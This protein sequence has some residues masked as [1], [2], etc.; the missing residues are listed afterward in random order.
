MNNQQAI[1]LLHPDTTREALQEKSHE[2]S[3]K[4][5][6]NACVLACEAL[7]NYNPWI[8]AT[9][10]PESG[11]RVCVYYE[12]GGLYWTDFAIY[13]TKQDVYW[14]DVETDGF[15]RYDSEYGYFEVKNVLCWMKIP[16]PSQKVV[17]NMLNKGD[18]Q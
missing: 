16:M 5:I 6:E 9:T 13:Y 3:I 12:T 10:P 4:L 17:N 11:E 18:L 2:E 15:Y 1:Y 7:E 14:E 8:P